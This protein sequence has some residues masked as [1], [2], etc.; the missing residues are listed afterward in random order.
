MQAAASSKQD[1]RG[2][3]DVLVVV[4]VSDQP[5][6]WDRQLTRQ[7]SSDRT[8]DRLVVKGESERER[9]QMVRNNN[10]Q[11]GKRQKRYT[12]GK[13][14]DDTDKGTPREQ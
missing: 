5:V 12:R 9:K 14:E 1:V 10:K 6:S 8:S 11:G 7:Q 3:E 13:K 4:I 2:V